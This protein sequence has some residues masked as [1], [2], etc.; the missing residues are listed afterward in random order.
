MLIVLAQLKQFWGTKVTITPISL[1][2]A[3]L[4]LKIGDNI[5][6]CYMLVPWS[7]THC[8][9][10]L[11]IDSS[12]LIISSTCF[13]VRLV[14]GSRKLFLSG[15]NCRKFYVNHVAL[16]FCAYLEYLVLPLWRK[17]F[18]WQLKKL[19]FLCFQFI[20]HSIP[21]FVVH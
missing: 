4:I 3:A 9:G 12:P 18:Y 19:G 6:F 16:R 11:V 15:Q 17:Q 7:H 8:F 13:I 20:S 1:I 2:Y 14:F 5:V 21:Y 10:L